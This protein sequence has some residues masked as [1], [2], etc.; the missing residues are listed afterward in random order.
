MSL[1][2][3]NQPDY[4]IIWQLAWKSPHIFSYLQCLSKE[5]VLCITD[6]IFSKPVLKAWQFVHKALDVKCVADV[7]VIFLNKLTLFSNPK[8]VDLLLRI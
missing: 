3:P 1:C 2:Y 7:S 4:V 5:Y 6:T 8:V